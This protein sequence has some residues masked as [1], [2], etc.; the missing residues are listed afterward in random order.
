MLAIVRLMPMTERF[1]IAS[2]DHEFIGRVYDLSI[3]G[4]N[5]HT[6]DEVEKYP[7]AAY[8]LKTNERL[9][10]LVRRVESLNHIGDLLWPETPIEIE[11]LSL[12]AYDYCNLIQDAFLMRIISIIDC[13]C[14]LAVEVLKL[15]IKPRQANIERIRLAS[16]NHPCCDKL[17]TLSNVQLDLREER[18][19]RFHRGIQDELTDDDTTFQTVARFKHWG[20]GMTGTDR[21]GRAIDLDRSFAEAI[22][23]L[24]G[25]FSKN[26]ENLS[27]ALSPFYDEMHEEF[28]KRFSPK[29]NAENGFGRRF[30]K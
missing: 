17:Q 11:K 13:C 10:L 7:D 24:R 15:S 30:K 27:N 14:L 20:Q 19:I 18:N 1:I 26:V 9:S 29:F 8:A 25:K 6:A 5:F 16:Q 21:Y 4:L 3:V 2:D 12:S 23:Y 22:E 28:D